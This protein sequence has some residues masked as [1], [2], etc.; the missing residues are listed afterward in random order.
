MNPQGIIGKRHTNI[1]T[2]KERSTQPRTPNVYHLAQEKATLEDVLYIAGYECLL[3]RNLLM[4]MK[5]LCCNK[6][7][8]GGLLEDLQW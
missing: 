7:L 2:G 8:T 4:L 6:S 3:K 1:L 5:T